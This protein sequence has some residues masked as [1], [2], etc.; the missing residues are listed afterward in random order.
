MLTQKKYNEKL[1]KR[2]QNR[3]HRKSFFKITK[4]VDKSIADYM[5]VRR[6]K[7]IGL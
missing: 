2:E 1:K 4:S 6:M 7:K 5:E 3:K